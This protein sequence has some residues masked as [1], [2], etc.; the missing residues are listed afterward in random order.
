MISTHDEGC[1]YLTEY[2]ERSE[3][4]TPSPLDLANAAFMRA[5]Q[6]GDILSEDFERDSYQPL[7]DR[8]QVLAQL[9]AK[10]IAQDRDE[11]ARLFASEA[12]KVAVQVDS[13]DKAR[14]DGLTRPVPFQDGRAKVRGRRDG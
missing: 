7:I 4:G 11:L 6:A 2:I 8:A 9:T 10:A 13:F 3:A 12:E 5:S 14:F 1:A